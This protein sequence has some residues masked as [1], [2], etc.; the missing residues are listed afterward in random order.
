MGSS[1]LRIDCNSFIFRMFRFER[2][3]FLP[4]PPGSVFIFHSDPHNIAKISPWFLHI[5][6][7]DAAA[8]ARPGDRFVLKLRIFGF[9]LRWQGL[10]EAVAVPHLLVDTGAPFPFRSWRHEHQFAAVPGGTR[11]TDVVTY[12]MVGGWL[13]ALLG[14]TVF[15]LQLL[16]MFIGRHR[17]TAGYFAGQS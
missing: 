5:Q 16:I 12:D 17:A 8:E 15:R 3:I 1:S 4:A 10:W 11:M 13:G 9:P 6:S 7:I 2:S 14:C